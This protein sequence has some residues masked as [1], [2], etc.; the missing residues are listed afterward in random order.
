MS[1]ASYVWG[2]FILTIIQGKHY[3]PHFSREKTEAQEGGEL[4]PSV[5][6]EIDGPQC[7]Q[8]HLSSWLT[9][10]FWL[11]RLPCYLG[12]MGEVLLDGENQVKL[13]LYAIFLA[14]DVAVTCCLPALCIELQLFPVPHPVDNSSASQPLKS[15]LPNEGGG[16]WHMDVSCF[17]IQEMKVTDSRLKEN[18]PHL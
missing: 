18:H 16:T 5:S 11:L 2:H 3:Y 8:R 1:D 10:L 15:F 7:E 14:I 9:G 13:S 12:L 6:E 17:Q 4:G